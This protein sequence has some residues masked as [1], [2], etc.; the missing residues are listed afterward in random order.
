MCYWKSFY[1]GKQILNVY[2]PPSAGV[3]AYDCAKNLWQG[4]LYDLRHWVSIKP[5][6]IPRLVFTEALTV[7]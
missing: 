1:W 4:G 5:T 7:V 6:L 2:C 3:N